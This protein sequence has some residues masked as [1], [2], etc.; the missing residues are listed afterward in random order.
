M[1]RFDFLCHYR[2]NPDLLRQIFEL[3]DLAFP[4]LSLSVQERAARPLGCHW[5]EVS[6]PFVYWDGERPVS[7]VGV[8]EI[9]MVLEGREVRVG[10]VH[11]VCT[12]PD[13]R[14]R[15]LYKTL[16]AEVMSW[17]EDRYQT[18]VLTTSQSFLYEP[19]GFRVMPECRFTGLLAGVPEGQGVRQFDFGRAR[20]VALL[21]R[22]LSARAPVSLFLGIVREQAVFTFNEALRPL[23]YSDKLD[24]VLSLEIEGT[25]LR[26]FDVVGKKPPHLF[27][28]VEMVPTPIERVEVYFCP[29]QLGGN[30]T[31]ESHILSGDD[32]LM[33]RGRF[34]PEGKPF[35]LPRS[36]RC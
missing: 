13:F 16:M 21:R 8:L 36:A 12:H 32:L 19:F 4:G 24:V 14:G 27:E 25:T 1:A 2:D 7:H 18:L 31:P 3:L 30:L 11:A 34:L 15:G 26:L 28:I 9:P 23:H 10:G 5:E 22:V 17:C 33:V 29:D 35:M 20:D 6:T